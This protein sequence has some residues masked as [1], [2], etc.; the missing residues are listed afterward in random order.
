MIGLLSNV[1]KVEEVV[2]DTCTGTSATAKAFL[3]VPAHSQCATGEKRFASFQNVLSSLV[4]VYTKQVLSSDYGIAWREGTDEKRKF[5][6]VD[7]IS[8]AEMQG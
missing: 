5:F 4:V 3:Q 7:G 8:R 2:P 1:S 6:E